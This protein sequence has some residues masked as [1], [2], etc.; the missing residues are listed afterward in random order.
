LGNSSLG[1]TYGTAAS[2][3][4][5]LTWVYYTSIIL[6]FGAEFTKV[7]ALEY[8]GGIIPSEMAVFII[9]QESKEIYVRNKHPETDKV[10]EISKEETGDNK[11]AT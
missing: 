9:K 1:A 7:H 4:I 10:S 8:G 11:T 6:Y 3:I 5:I 2:I